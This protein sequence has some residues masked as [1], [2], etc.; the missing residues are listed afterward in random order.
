MFNLISL[1][2]SDS[3]VSEVVIFLEKTDPHFFAYSWSEFNDF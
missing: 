1:N 2:T 3:V